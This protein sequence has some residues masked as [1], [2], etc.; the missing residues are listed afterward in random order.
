MSLFK[1]RFLLSSTAYSIYYFRDKGIASSNNGIATTVV[2][3][4][5]LDCAEVSAADVA[6]GAGPHN[7][8]AAGRHTGIPT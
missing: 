2:A 6:A 5:L 1:V 3:R 4:T 7:S 8:F